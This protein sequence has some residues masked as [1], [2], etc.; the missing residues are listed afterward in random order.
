MK[1]TVLLVLLSFVLHSC[2]KGIKVDL[3]IHNAQIHSMDAS[4][5]IYQAMAIQ[6]G[7]IIELGSERQILNRYRSKKEVDAY[8]KSIY[9][10]FS[11]AHTHLLLAANERLS[12]NLKEAKTIE[13]AIVTLEKFHSRNTPSFMIGRGIHLLN[14][15][16]QTTL[17]DKISHTFPSTPVFIVGRDGHSAVINE[18]AMT[19][20]AQHLSD[21]DL[22]SKV[23][24]TSKKGFLDEQLFFDVYPFFPKFAAKEIENKLF[25]I[26]DEFLQYGIV[27]VHEMGLSKEDF[28]FL[29]A[30][31]KK[32]KWL[33]HI[34]AYLLPTP[35]NKQLLAA[36]DFQAEKIQINGIKLFIDG[37]FGSKTAAI[38]SEYIDG[39][40]GKINY[41]AN[42]LDSILL[43]TA[44]NELQLSAHAAGDQ[45]AAFLLERIE[46]LQLNINNLNWRIEHLQKITPELVA[47]IAEL[48]LIPSLQPFHAMS[49]IKWLHHV[50]PSIDP[51]FYAYKSLFSANEMI[52][53]GSDMPIETFNPFEIIWAATTRKDLDNPSQN[54]FYEKE[55]LSITEAIKSYSLYNAMI[56]KTHHLLGSLEADRNATFFIADKP[57]ST[58]H[59]STYNFATKVYINSKEVYSVE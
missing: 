27:A 21:K 42:Q 46:K 34:S 23:Q 19:Y 39:T 7:K 59:Q 41:T 54:A 22:L 40:Q 18:K 10:G 50:I 47:K 52:G 58:E 49:D 55:R 5:T 1:K 6:D 11:D 4:N 16:I 51:T 32:E 25:E 45:A 14:D 12:V 24:N 9:P 17:F 29:H 37:T 26:Q 3:I 13:Q 33:L 35:E 56:S 2:F 20:L 30:V 28:D 15:S 38:S 31:S 36:K 57:I 53:I 44:N 43:F 8:G 48:H